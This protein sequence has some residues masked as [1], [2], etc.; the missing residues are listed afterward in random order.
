MTF[1]HEAAQTAEREK[2]TG[3]R[4]AKR[5][6]EE[7]KAVMLIKK[8]KRRGRPQRSNRVWR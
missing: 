4:K 3:C 6:R 2:R 5:A 8:R 7:R 1:E